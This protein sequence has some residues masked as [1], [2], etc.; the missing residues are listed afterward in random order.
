MG[1]V[2]AVIAGAFLLWGGESD[3]KQRL[4]S[5]TEL[6]SSP[7]PPP[8]PLHGVAWCKDQVTAL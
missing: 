1:G 7:V 4:F 2:V 8:H 6:S 3:H 5:L